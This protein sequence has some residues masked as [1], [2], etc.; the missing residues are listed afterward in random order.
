MTK[1]FVMILKDW[2][3]I[4][5]IGKVWH[6]YCFK[7]VSKFYFYFKDI[8]TGNWRWCIRDGL[9]NQPRLVSIP[10]YLW[11]ISNWWMDVYVLSQNIIYSVFHLFITFMYPHPIFLRF[12]TEMNSF[13]CLLILLFPFDLLFKIKV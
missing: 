1:N 11:P 8:D 6:S 7:N 2:R 12:A 5:K 10:I 4:V 3:N 13:F 9:C